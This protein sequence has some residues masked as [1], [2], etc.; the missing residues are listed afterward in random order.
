MKDNDLIWIFKE[1]A[2]DENVLDWDEI[3]VPEVD[4]LEE[5]QWV[6]LHK[7]NLLNLFTLI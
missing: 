7:D 6:K 4:L 3:E 5:P 1:L 2:Y